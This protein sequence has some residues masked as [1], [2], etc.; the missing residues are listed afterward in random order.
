MWLC[1][2]AI[3]LY[4]ACVSVA[5]AFNSVHSSALPNESYQSL[6]HNFDSSYHNHS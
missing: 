5:L 4:K 2:L 3:T 1:I 6:Y